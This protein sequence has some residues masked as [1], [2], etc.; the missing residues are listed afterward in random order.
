M[1]ADWET[2]ENEREAVTIAGD[3]FIAVQESVIGRL[4]HSLPIPS[5]F[6]IDCKLVLYSLLY[7]P[8]FLITFIFIYLYYLWYEW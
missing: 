1:Y 5:P 6:F 4:F 2:K 3:I 7:T 8:P